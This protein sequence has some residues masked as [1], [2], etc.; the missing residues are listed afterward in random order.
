MPGQAAF[1]EN[2]VRADAALL[3]DILAVAPWL[4]S[5]RRHDSG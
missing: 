1:Q 5:A 2:P 4:L 3:P